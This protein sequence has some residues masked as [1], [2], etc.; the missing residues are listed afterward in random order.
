[1]FIQENVPAYPF[2][3]KLRL[4]LANTHR[5]VR[6]VVGPECLGWPSRRP[7]SFCC[8][9]ALGRLR[10][11]GPETDKEV[12]EEF[13][14]I[15]K[16]KILLDGNVFRLAG[17]DEV[18]KWY[19]QKLAARGT[20]REPAALSDIASLLEDI[21]PPGARMRLEAYERVRQETL[22]AGPGRPG[23][24]AFIADV[25]Q[26][27]HRASMC[28]PGF[29]CQLT[30]GTVVSMSGSPDGRRVFL[31]S[32]HLAAMG[33]HLFEQASSTFSSPVKGLLCS[34]SGRAQKALAGN[35]MSL[36]ALA[37]VALYFWAN[38]V[39]EPEPA[40]GRPSSRVGH[41]LSA[42]SQ[43]APGAAAG[44]DENLGGSEPSPQPEA[45]PSEPDP[46]RAAAERDGI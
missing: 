30:H 28:G 5:I 21:L 41:G 32:E 6:V 23:E 39:R 43:H 38:T 46:E 20:Y 24:A 33:W 35:A 3:V 42:P 40:S 17:E 22:A 11:V 8:G 16:R 1:M 14:S 44:Q 25:E 9:L 18:R 15:F 4:P 13:D 27:P 37:A 12:Q 36:P 19:S 34:L 29:P 45:E 2:K 31:G 26:W 7:R 10:W